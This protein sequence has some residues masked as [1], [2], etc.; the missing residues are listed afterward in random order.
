MKKN[1]NVAEILES[2]DTII[3][4]NKYSANKKNKSMT[5]NQET[6]KIIADAENSQSNQ[7]FNKTLILDNEF[8]E[9]NGDFNEENYLEEKIFPLEDEVLVDDSSDMINL[10]EKVFPIEQEYI[11]ENKKE[12]FIDTDGDI[13]KENLKQKEKIK[14][15]N[16]LL[17]S[18]L[19]QKRYI[20]LD[21]KIKLYQADN[22]TLR[23]KIHDFSNK[24][25]ALRL[26]LTESQIN[27]NSEKIK[28]EEHKQPFVLS[29]DN[30]NILSEEILALKK[31]NVYL[32]NELTRIK[33]NQDSS[34]KNNDE[35]FKFYREEYAKVIIDK[36]E[37][38]RKLENTKQKLSMNEKNK[39]ELRL[40]LDNLNRIIE[41]TDIETTTFSNQK[42][43]IKKY[44]L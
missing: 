20:E 10:E 35:K 9:N 31:K 14:D 16:I 11:E 3:T 4:G 32:E 36:S 26:K 18:F 34:S 27:E 8:I 30:I 7:D 5:K 42:D 6:E 13:K 15:L 33:S 2:V 40:A 37:I 38:L 25:A 43:K 29:N 21:D 44:K 39:H 28:N 12:D 41:S 22:A 24:E 17:D 23:K 19:S 1:F